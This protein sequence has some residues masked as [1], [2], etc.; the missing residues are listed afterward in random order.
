MIPGSSLGTVILIRTTAGAGDGGCVHSMAEESPN[1]GFLG[2]RSTLDL[3][4]AAS[5]ERIKLDEHF[6]KLCVIFKNRK[7]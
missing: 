5:A 3:A 2:S 6:C 7:E 1:L 4:A